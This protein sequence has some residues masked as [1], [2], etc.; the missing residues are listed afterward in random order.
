MLYLHVSHSREIAIGSQAKNLLF[1]F[2]DPL[3]SAMAAISKLKLEG[4]VFNTQNG[5]TFNVQTP[6]PLSLCAS[7]D[8]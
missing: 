1:A 7:L 4:H 8:Q 2:H 3:A 5:F 6:M